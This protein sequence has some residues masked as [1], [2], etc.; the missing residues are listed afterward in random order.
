MGTVDG[1]GSCLAM[2][3][4]AMTGE[5]M[6]V[7]C[8]SKL[9]VACARPAN[10]RPTCT[11]GPW[12]EGEVVKTNALMLNLS[13]IMQTYSPGYP[14]DASVPCDYFLSVAAGKRVQVEVDF[15][16][17]QDNNQT[18]PKVLLLEAN[19]CCDHLLLSDD[20]LGGNIVANLTGEITDET[21][22]TQSSNFMRVSW[23]PNKGVNVRGMMVSVPEKKK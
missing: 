13:E 18:N 19:S 16:S 10:P 17:I 14:Y 9:A 4:F 7:D 21:Y 8:S 6:N 1:H 20:M 5:W 12:K 15:V 3:T 23:L 11:S 2:D 22:T